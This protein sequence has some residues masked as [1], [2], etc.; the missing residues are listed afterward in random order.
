M[1]I[2][3]KLAKFRPF[4][5]YRSKSLFKI[6]RIKAT[7]TRVTA[8]PHNNMVKDGNLQN[9]ARGAQNTGNGQILFTRHRRT[10]RMV[11]G[12]N[13]RHGTVLDCLHE[14]LAR[15]N[16]RTVHQPLGQFMHT[17]DMV[18]ESPTRSAPATRTSKKKA[19]RQYLRDFPRTL[20]FRSRYSAPKAPGTQAPG[21]P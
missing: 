21:S 8:L 2:V 10:R 7:D 4:L 16:R 14:S 18:R 19:E 11:M 9:T 20:P 17:D 1:T 15:V 3:P 12:E 6:L 13:Y 5:V